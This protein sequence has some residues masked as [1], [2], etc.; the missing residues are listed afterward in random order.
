[1]ALRACECVT[2]SGVYIDHVSELFSNV[3]D[4]DP[5]R[6]ALVGNW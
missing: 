4:S 3:A 5:V 1:M 2:E 6:N